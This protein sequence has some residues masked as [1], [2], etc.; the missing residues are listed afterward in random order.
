MPPMTVIKE[1]SLSRMM[2]SLPRARVMALMASWDND[3]AHGIKVI[4]PQGAA[5][6][7]LTA[8]HRHQP[9]ADDLRHISSGVDAQAQDSNLGEIAAADEYHGAPNQQLDHHGGA[10]D[11]GDVHLAYPVEQAEDRVP[12]AVGALLVVG[13]AHQSHQ[14]PQDYAQD[15]GQSS[16]GEGGPG[17]RP[18]TV[19]A[20]RLNKRPYRT[21]AIK[22]LP[23]GDGVCKYWVSGEH[24]PAP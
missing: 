13:G 24:H 11:D 10:A 8:V 5:R 18:D 22:F 15:Q 12:A 17:S 19:S 16:G 9:A 7:H 21:S 1:V 23:P 6:L 4:Q 2:N 3:E 14:D 20:V